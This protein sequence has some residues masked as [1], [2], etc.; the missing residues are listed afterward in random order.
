MSERAD[1]KRGVV[2]FLVL[3]FG[4]AWAIEI[5]LYAAGV[6]LS[7]PIAAAGLVLVMF[8]PGIAAFIIRRFITCEGF[9]DVGLRLGPLRYY[10]SAWFGMPAVAFLSLGLARG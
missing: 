3:A 10:A 2:W 1:H 7:S 9:A 5:G 4:L 6:P 8:T